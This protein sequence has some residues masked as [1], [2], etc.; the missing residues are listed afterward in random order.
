M[1][2]RSDDV[3]D[4]SMEDEAATLYQAAYAIANGQ[5]EAAGRFG[6]SASTAT[7]RGLWRDL[8]RL[9]ERVRAMGEFGRWRMAVIEAGI[10]DARSGR[11]PRY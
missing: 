5:A 9:R 10:S 2:D 1:A 3:E 6:P 7:P 4:V 8:E 11:P